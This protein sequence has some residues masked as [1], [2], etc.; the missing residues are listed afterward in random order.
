ME[1]VIIIGGGIAGMSAATILGRCRRRVLVIDSGKPRN[2]ASRGLHGF[3]TRD[4]AD[5]FEMRAIGRKQ[6]EPYDTVRWHEG[7]AVDAFRTDESFEVIVSDGSRWESRYLVLATGIVDRLPEVEG[8]EDLY[9]RSVFHC[10][11]CD[12]WENRDRMLAAYGQ[13]EGGVEL[14]LELLTWSRDVVLCTDGRALSREA[15]ERLLR[16][17]VRYNERKVLRLE[18]TEGLLDRMIFEDGTSLQR[19]A[20]FFYPEQYQTSPLAE[21]L[22]CRVQEGGV[23]ETG[24]LQGIQPRLFAVGDAVRSV[25]LAIVAAAKG[26][27]AAF[28]INTAMQQEEMR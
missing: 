20:L 17:E 21:K 5:P 6:L 11:Y 23:L 12:G 25:Q 8:L 15:A 22:G 10:P 28:A 14:A 7:T 27:E 18:G 1:E 26:A 9:G 16:N 4:G 24:K 13:G 3:L 19:E 2:G